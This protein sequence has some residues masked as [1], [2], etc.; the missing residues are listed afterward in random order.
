MAAR[1]AQQRCSFRAFCERR[2]IDALR[3]KWPPFMYPKAMM[4][5]STSTMEIDSM[6]TASNAEFLVGDLAAA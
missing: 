6:R 2:W 5:E 1:Q 4:V 3:R